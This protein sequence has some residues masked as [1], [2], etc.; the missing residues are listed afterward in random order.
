VIRG[1]V[2]IVALA[3]VTTGCSDDDADDNDEPA[4]AEAPMLGAWHELVTEDVWEWSG[5]PATPAVRVPAGE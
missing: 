1:L 4:S 5:D 2:G 3:L